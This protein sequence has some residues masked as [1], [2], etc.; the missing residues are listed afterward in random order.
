MK[1]TKEPWRKGLVSTCIVADE[2]VP[3]LNGSDAT[4][5]YGGKSIMRYIEV[6]I[7]GIYSYKQVSTYFMDYMHEAYLSNDELK[8]Y[9]DQLKSALEEIES[10]IEEHVDGK[11]RIDAQI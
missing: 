11:D 2:P 10:A 3:E 5:Y 9:R 7:K 6:T 4:E 1:H 8:E